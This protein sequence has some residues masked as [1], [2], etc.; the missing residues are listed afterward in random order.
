MSDTDIKVTITEQLQQLQILMNRMAFRNYRNRSRGRS[1]YR[2]QGRV[3]AVLKMKPEISQ[4]ELTY[5]LGM[6]RQSMAELLAK[7]ERAGY[8]TREP[9]EEDKR[10]MMIKLTEEGLANADAMGNNT[11]EDPHALDSL[12]QDELTQ[13]SEY[14]RR[15][16]ESYEVLFPEEE[17]EQRRRTMEAFRS[18]PERGTDRFGRFRNARG[19]SRRSR[20]DRPGRTAQEPEQEQQGDDAEEGKE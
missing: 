13:L 8:I 9:S 14:L 1:P 18:Q 2:G 15:I 12:D 3:L 11:D 4:R 20:Q 19:Y 7:L 17:Y 10:V 5:L 6:S 16:I